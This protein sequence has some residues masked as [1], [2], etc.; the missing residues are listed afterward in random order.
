MET[1]FTPM[2][3]LIGGIMIGLSAL[4]LMLFLGRIAGATGI[5]AGTFFATSLGDWSWRAAFLAGMIVAPLIASFASV[6]VQPI[7]VPAGLAALAIGG[8]IVGAGVT[9]GSGCTSG[10][11]VCGMARLSARSLVATLVFMAATGATVFLTRHVI[12]G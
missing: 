2:A 10:H 9:I 12:G 6:P 5:L 7:D 1:E 8:V 3:S 4:V 11:G